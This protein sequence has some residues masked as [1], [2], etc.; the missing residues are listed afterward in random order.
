MC[1]GACVRY[2]KVAVEALQNLRK[3]LLFLGALVCLLL[4]FDIYIIESEWILGKWDGKVWTQFMWLRIGFQ[5][6]AVVNMVMNLWV[7]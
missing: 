7:L 6:Q 4:I 5:W 1:A 2:N 3:Q